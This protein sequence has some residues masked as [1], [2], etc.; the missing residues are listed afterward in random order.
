MQVN[1]MAEKLGI[2]M[3][4]DNGM[5]KEKLTLLDSEKSDQLDL[6]DF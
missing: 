5:L 2:E 1:E 4:H 3:Q 6:K